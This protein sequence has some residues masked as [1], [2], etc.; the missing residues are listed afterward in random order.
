M[1]DSDEANEDMKEVENSDQ[2]NDR[3][4]SSS[5]EP[6]MSR[7]VSDGQKEIQRVCLTTVEKIFGKPIVK[8]S[9]PSSRFS[10]DRTDIEVN[11][12]D[13]SEGNSE[14]DNDSQPK[15]EKLDSDNSSNH[16]RT[17]GLMSFLHLKR[18]TS[19]VRPKERKRA[20]LTT[21]SSANSRAKLES[22]SGAKL[23]V[24]K[25][26]EQE[27]FNMFLINEDDNAN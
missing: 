13:I 15:T 7:K 8:V 27:C 10:S 18:T 20:V 12:T 26:A 3:D 16:S 5:T 1:G 23:E 25:S 19:D 17:G 9:N 21:I 2:K 14:E 4:V 22:E 6:L 11:E 24:S